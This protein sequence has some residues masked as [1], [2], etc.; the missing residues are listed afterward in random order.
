MKNYSICVVGL[1]YVGLPLA[2]AFAEK[3][4][5]IGFDNSEERISQLKDGYDKTQEL[6]SS[7]LESVDSNMTYTSNIQATVSTVL[8]QA[9]E[10]IFQGHPETHAITSRN[11]AK[12]RLPVFSHDMPMIT[13]YTLDHD[14]GPA[15]IHNACVNPTH[16]VT[17]NDVWCAPN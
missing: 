3:F 6:D 17:R 4:E 9:F 1:G 2:T 13:F 10:Y 8:L 11:G 15:A 16:A 7:L 12:L 14:V 5:V